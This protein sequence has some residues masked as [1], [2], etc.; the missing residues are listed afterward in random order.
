MSK[1][2][3]DMYSNSHAV[4]AR[5]VYPV[6]LKLLQEHE[7]IKVREPMGEREIYVLRICYF[8]ILELGRSSTEA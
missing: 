7:H 3:I 1:A 8:A 2:S 4:F 5:T 6:N